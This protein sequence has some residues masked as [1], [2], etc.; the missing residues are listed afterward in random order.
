MLPEALNTLASLVERTIQFYEN[1]TDRIAF[2]RVALD[3]NA[4]YG[5][6]FV[7]VDTSTS[8]APNEVLFSES[9]ESFYSFGDWA[10]PDIV[11]T[12]SLIRQLWEEEWEPL[13]RVIRDDWLD[14]PEVEHEMRKKRLLEVKSL[15]S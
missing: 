3:C 7:A 8:F 4:D 13:Q 9:G 6:V 1:S 14:L 15:F 2:T 10:I 12:N 11:D 5:D